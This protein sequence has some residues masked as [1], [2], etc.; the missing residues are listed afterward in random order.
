LNLFTASLCALFAANHGPAFTVCR[1]DA[2]KTGA[3]PSA[4]V[5][6]VTDI[7]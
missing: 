1:E 6:G 3:L 7:T 4:Q 2:A 5:A